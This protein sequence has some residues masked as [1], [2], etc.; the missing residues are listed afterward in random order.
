M[1]LSLEQIK[2]KIQ[3][4][5][6]RDLLDQ[7]K[8]NERELKLFYSKS[9]DSKLIQ[10]LIRPIISG[11]K[12]SKFNKVYKNWT[13]PIINKIETHYSKV[14]TSPGAVFDFDFGDNIDA[15]IG[16]DLIREG[17]YSGVSDIKYW[18]KL[19]HPI[20]I[21]QPDS[22]YVTG[23][24]KEGAINIKHVPLKYIHDIDA[25]EK[26]V[27]YLIVKKKIKIDGVE[28]TF[29]HVWDDVYSYNLVEG[30][31][32]VELVVINNQAQVFEH[33]AKKCPVERASTDYLDTDNFILMK[34]II[35]DSIPDLYEYLILKTFYEYYKYYSAFGKEIKAQ[36]RCDYKSEEDNV[37]C[38]DGQLSVMHPGKE[39]RMYH[40]K[41]CP[42]CGGGD[43]GDL[44]GEIIEIPLMMQGNSDFLG[45]LGALFNRVDADTGI[46]T[47]HSE[48]LEKIESKIY[49]DSIGMGFGEGF[50]RQA[51]NQDQVRASYDDIE[52][53]LNDYGRYTEQT[54]KYNLDRAAEMWSES[55]TSS[56]YK[57]GKNHFIKDTGILY[58]ELK[59]IKE[60][61]SN[62]AMIDKKMQEILMTES[63]NDQKLLKRAK[64]IQQVIPFN[65]FTDEYVSSNLESLRAM[66]SDAVDIYLN[67]FQVISIFEAVHGPL[68]EF[69]SGIL[70]EFGLPDEGTTIKEI[71]KLFIQILDEY[72]LRTSA[73]SGGAQLRTA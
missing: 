20:K 13:K 69:G 36:T 27:E 59:T 34:S 47:F 42:K 5:K 56:V 70:N 50:R 71:N 67:K 62:D 24:S 52:S 68:S 64:R 26:G 18:E 49:S 16:F 51:V 21:T 7:A 14:F 48:D 45:N 58:E 12:L 66:N 55:F 43:K 57:Y 10:D 6:N 40:D 17:I 8:E 1:I 65:G 9:G 38:R 73:E 15:K 54:V 37:V 33:G 3:S 11:K 4:P 61:T 25:T 28:R 39:F 44:F 31:E 63:R 53:N 32:G 22:C 60:T 23:T 19:G 41:S 46:L 30:E 29:Y 2:E 35:S 72:G